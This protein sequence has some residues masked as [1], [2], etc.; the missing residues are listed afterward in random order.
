MGFKKNDAEMPVEIKEDPK[1]SYTVEVTSAKVINDN[2][3]IFNAV[4]NGIKID[5]FAL[6]EYTNQKKETGYLIQFPSHKVVKDGK[7]SWFH[8]V[9]FPISKELRENIKNQVISLIG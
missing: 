6:V 7:E 4:V 2:R 8:T 1:Y 5:G 3:V 9:W